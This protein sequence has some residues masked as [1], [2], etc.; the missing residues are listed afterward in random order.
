MD[1]AC[2]PGAPA[3]LVAAFRQAMREL[4]VEV[5]VK[6]IIYKLFDRYVLAGIDELYDDINNELA[7]AGVLPQLRHEISTRRSDAPAPIG[8]VSNTAAPIQQ[9]VAPV[10]DAAAAEFMQSLHALFSARR[11][12]MPSGAGP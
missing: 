8:P 9:A 2:N 1:D 12:S 6:L 11:D 3:A 4:M 10:T 7:T 5:R